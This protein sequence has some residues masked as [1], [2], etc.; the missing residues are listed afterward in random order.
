MATIE[1]D[2]IER[3]NETRLA[4]H[5]AAFDGLATGLAGRGVDVDAISDRYDFDVRRVFWETWE[6]GEE[7]G[8]LEWQGSRVRLTRSGRLRSNELFAELV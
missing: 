6:R 2:V 5:K 7:A 4:A 8:V 1:P 3:E